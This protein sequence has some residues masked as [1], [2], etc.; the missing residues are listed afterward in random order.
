MMQD[1]EDGPDEYGDHVDGQEDEEAEK[2]AIVAASDAIIDPRTVVV[3]RL[4]TR[5]AVGTVGAAGWPIELACDAPLHPNSG[6]INFNSLVQWSSK[7]IINVFVRR[8]CY[9]K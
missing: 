1:K 5:V 8:C 4:H 6:T 9:E 3:K 2:V 7:V